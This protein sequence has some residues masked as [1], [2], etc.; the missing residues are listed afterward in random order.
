MNK[1]LG[2]SV[3]LVVLLI[4]IFGCSQQSMNSGASMSNPASEYCVSLGGDLAI[5]KGKE[6]QIG[7]CRLPDGEIIEE[8]LLYR[9]DH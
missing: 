2:V 4:L 1:H 8:W 6:G 9:R 3:V 7:V 5:K